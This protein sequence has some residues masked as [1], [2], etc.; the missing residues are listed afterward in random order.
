VALPQ[1][2]ATGSYITVSGIAGSDI[3]VTLPGWPAVRTG[4]DPRVFLS[5]ILQNKLPRNYRL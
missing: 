5:R 1:V 4:L 3:A 2:T